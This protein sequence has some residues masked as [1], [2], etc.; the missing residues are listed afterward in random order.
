MKPVI[1]RQ[2]HKGSVTAEYMIV[3]FFL[4]IPIWYVFVGGSG[5]WSDTE[6]EPNHGN[7][8]VGQLP[9]EPPALVRTLNERQKNF[10]TQIN[11]P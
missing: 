7:L 11:Q 5:D 10:T 8:S 3:A 6:R 1:S 9:A 2:A 4:M